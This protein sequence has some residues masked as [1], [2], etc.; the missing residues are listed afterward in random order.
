MGRGLCST[1]D[2]LPYIGSLPGQRHTYFALGF[3]G[4]GITFSV[5]AGQ[6]IAGLAGGKKDGIAGIFSFAR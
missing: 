2:G 3:G 1:K 5:I 6:I 4:N